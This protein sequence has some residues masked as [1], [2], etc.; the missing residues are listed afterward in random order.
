[1]ACN[2]GALLDEPTR[3]LDAQHLC[4]LCVAFTENG[5]LLEWVWRQHARCSLLYVS[6]LAFGV[7]VYQASKLCS[8][9]GGVNSF[10]PLLC[11]DNSSHSTAWMPCC[12]RQVETFMKRFYGKLCRVCK[13]KSFPSPGVTCSLPKPC[14]WYVDASCGVR[15]FVSLLL[16]ARTYLQTQAIIRPRPC[17]LLRACA[18]TRYYLASP[19][20][21]M[22]VVEQRG[23]LGACFLVARVYVVAFPFFF[24]FFVDV[25]VSVA[26]YAST[27]TSSTKTKWMSLLSP[28]VLRLQCTIFFYTQLRQ[29]ESSVQL[30]LFF[31]HFFFFFFFLLSCQFAVS[32]WRNRRRLLFWLYLLSAFF[33]FHL[34]LLVL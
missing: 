25:L 33:F 31:F 29:C 17:D 2:L 30:I 34:S 14:L 13:A 7:F 5:I 19:R 8:S 22:C 32:S 3:S 18:V 6:R 24:F 12:G 20:S 15:P 26:V 4:Y 28:W 9:C 16:V 1:M 21:V 27:S 11:Q 10:W 23:T